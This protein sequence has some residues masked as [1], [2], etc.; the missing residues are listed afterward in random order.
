MFD[1]FLANAVLMVGWATVVAGVVILAKNPRSHVDDVLRDRAKRIQS[2][3]AVSVGFALAVAGM[4][5]VCASNWI[6]GVP[7]L[8][9][10]LVFTA[11]VVFAWGWAARAA[12]ANA[13][14]IQ[15]LEVDEGY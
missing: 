3:R 15:E 14:R 2:L 7:G 11:A 4:T 12:R 9:N 13:Q 6:A 10:R 5:L 1:S 8:A